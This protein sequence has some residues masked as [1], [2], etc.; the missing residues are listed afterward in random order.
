MD[1]RNGTR[2]GLILL[3]GIGLSACAQLPKF[4]GGDA[5][6]QPI[7]T[8]YEPGSELPKELAEL[9]KEKPINPFLAG[10]SAKEIRM[11]KQEAMRTYGRDWRVIGVRSQYVRAPLLEALEEVNAPMELQIVPVVESSYNPYAESEVGASGLWQ[12]MPMTAGDLRIK[13]NKYFDGRRDITA[14]TKGAAKFLMRQYRRFGNWPM[15]FASYHLGPAAVQRRLDRR[16]WTPADGLKR[17]PLPPITKTYIRHLLGLIALHADGRLTFPE[18]FPTKIIKVQAPVDLAKLHEKS[19][20]PKH[21]IF[22]F[23]PKLALAQ[24]YG[25]KKAELTLRISLRRVPAIKKHLP[26]EPPRYTVITVRKGETMR[27]IC[28]AYGATIRDIRE[29]NRGLP[30][31]RLVAGQKIRIPTR[32]LSDDHAKANPLAKPNPT[33]VASNP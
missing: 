16:P 20:L 14:S 30:P 23:N 29:A 27:D 6:L 26:K 3:L 21:Q 4:G 5:K 17:M 28:D 33:L 7:V 32:L 22:R 8:P 18:P 25:D 12:L 10:L 1:K 19:N 9:S 15:A 13:S 24:Y 11:V 31:V 2:I